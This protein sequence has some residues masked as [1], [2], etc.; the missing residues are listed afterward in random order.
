MG[1]IVLESNV[2]FRFPIYD[3]FKGALFAD[4]GNVWL[5]NAN[6]NVPEAEFRFDTF[7]K[8]IALDAGLGLRADF[9]FFIFRVDFAWRLR[10]P[11][12][13]EGD[14]WVASKGIWFWNFGIGY[15]F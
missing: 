14:K 11:S 7:Y 8:Q 9:K 6:E 5:L 3:F 15:P 12:M 4:A 1:D 13:P 10:D 2:E